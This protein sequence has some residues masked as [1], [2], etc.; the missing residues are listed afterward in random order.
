MKE[1]KELI[2]S[3]SY[4]FSGIGK[5]VK[6]ERN[7]RIHIIAMLTIVIFN[8]MAR[9]PALSWA[10]EILCC[11]VVMSLELMNTALENACNAVTRAQNPWIHVAKD[12]AAGGVLVSAMGSVVVALLVFLS[13]ESYRINV[14]TYIREH[15]W[16]IT[17]LAIFAI[18]AAMFV[19]L[20]CRKKERE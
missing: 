18:A 13:E 11:M 6:S 3:F 15:L 17:C 7:F 20:P 16:V 2:R 9:L 19:F 5:A 10:I 14:V 1:V 8:G 4:G 12:A